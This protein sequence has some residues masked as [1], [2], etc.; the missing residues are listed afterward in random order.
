MIFEVDMTKSK[1]DVWENDWYECP[2]CGYD[3]IDVGFNHC[4]ACGEGL[5]MQVYEGG[6]E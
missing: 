4:P 3:S 5:L 6:E 1:H 2:S